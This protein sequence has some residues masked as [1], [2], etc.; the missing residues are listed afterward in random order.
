MEIVEEQPRRRSQR[1]AR[2]R[3]RQQQE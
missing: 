1:S 2:V 3:A